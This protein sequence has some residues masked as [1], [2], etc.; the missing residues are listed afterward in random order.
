M[1]STAGQSPSTTAR[2]FSSP[3]PAS[4]FVGSA[5]N[6]FWAPLT[7]VALRLALFESPVNLFALSP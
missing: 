2:T 3:E 7:D 6:K 5:H 4:G 1:L